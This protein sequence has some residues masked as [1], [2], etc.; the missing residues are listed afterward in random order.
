[1]C[2]NG[3]TESSG[4]PEQLQLVALLDEVGEQAR[5]GEVALDRA[6]IGGQAVDAQRQPELERAERARV[7]ERAVD[8]VLLPELVG[9]VGRLVA[10]GALEPLG[11]AHHEHAAGLGHEQPLVRVH[12]HGVGAGEAAEERRVA[13]HERGRQAVGA[14]DVQP[15]APRCAQTSASSS[16]GSTAPVSV[17]PAL[18]TTAIGATPAAR[19]ASIASAQA[20]TCMRRLRVDRDAAHAVAPDAEQLGRALD[21]LVHVGGG[22]ERAGTARQPGVA[23]AGQRALA[24]RGQRRHVR[25]RAAARERPGRDRVAEGL[26]EPLERLPLHEVGRARRRRRG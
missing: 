25:D 21:R 7:L 19:S 26:A 16:I 14:V 18:A 2:R 23:R 12:G 22:I 8:R 5:L 1:M 20:S 15:H 3:T 10:E 9:D 13:L 4:S 6:A 11:L 24:R 17:V